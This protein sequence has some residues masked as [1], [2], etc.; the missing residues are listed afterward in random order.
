MET[1]KR[2]GLV[3]IHKR[4]D[5]EDACTDYLYKLRWLDGFIYPICGC[6]EYYHIATRH[7]YA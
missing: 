7:K 6:R 4:F 1:K 2:V 5:A 3:D